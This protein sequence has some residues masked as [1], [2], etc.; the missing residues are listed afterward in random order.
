MNRFPKRAQARVPRLRGRS[1]PVLVT[2][3][4]ISG[5]LGFFSKVRLKRSVFISEFIADKSNKI[6]ILSAVMQD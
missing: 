3:K 4:V 1:N 2:N 6:S 5:I